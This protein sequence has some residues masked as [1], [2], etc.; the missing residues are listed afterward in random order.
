MLVDDFYT[1]GQSIT[2][3]IFDS[4]WKV[5]SECKAEEDKSEL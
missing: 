5:C 1:L 3:D 2:M 4:H